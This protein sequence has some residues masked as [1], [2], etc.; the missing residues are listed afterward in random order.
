MAISIQ[1]PHAQKVYS[2][3]MN[4]S[5]KIDKESAG[6]G[7]IRCYDFKRGYLITYGNK[8]KARKDAYIYKQKDAIFSHFIAEINK[9]Y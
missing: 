5:V 1:E 8:N 4:I 7:E 9:C 3:G 6:D 2:I